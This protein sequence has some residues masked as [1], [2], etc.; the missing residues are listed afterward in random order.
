MNTHLSRRK[1]LASALH[2]AALAAASPRRAAAQD[3]RAKRPNIVFIL[4]DDLGW[5]DTAAY[6]SK[7]Y[8][9]PN[10]T[11]L[12]ERGMLFTEGYAACPLCSPTRASILTG[13]YPARLRFT[14]PSGHL[15]TNL[16]PP[17]VP[18]AVAKSRP[19]TTPTSP[20]QLGLE[21]VTIAEILKNAGYA[22][23]FVGKWHLG[24]EPYWPDKQ[25]F[26]VNVAGGHYPGPPSYF[27]P[28]SIETLAD[29]PEGEYLTD[30][31]TDEA[32]EFIEAQRSGPFFLALWHYTV[33]S[34]WQS[35]AEEEARFSEKADPRG[36]QRNPLIAGMIAS[37]DQSVGRILDALD[38]H[39][40]SEDTIVVFTSDNGQLTAVPGKPGRERKNTP[41]K[42]GDHVT[43]NAPLRGGKGL[44]YEG[45]VRVPYIVSWPGVVAPGSRTRAIASSIDF[46]PTFLAAAG[47]DAPEGHV[48]DGVSLLPVLTN[49]GALEREALFCH[50]P[51]YV[52]VGNKPSTSVRK[53][54][55]KLIRF[56]EGY[57]EL[58]DLESDIGERNNLAAVH[59]QKVAE[60]SELI[61]RFLVG[62]NAL[63]PKPN[64]N[65]D[66]AA[67]PEEEGGE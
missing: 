29:G 3:L 27:S 32:L 65:Y 20:T 34:P 67:P 40:L 33:H 2:A 49:A 58:Y 12:A 6:G 24:R 53:G 61:D 11:R 19:L 41:L 25:G 1:F 9:T 38:V 54:S 36:E 57:D 63:V 48:V 60:L 64:P 46:F 42:S 52:G 14:Q 17:S 30:R 26:D 62:T 28:Y 13:Q 8:E 23:G 4:A 37:F 59:P 51:H 16:E 31:L 35:K 39:G 66:P 43:S 56:Y 18:D 44:I 7:Y 22:T 47:L 50:F 45:G 21:T 55:W 10:I 15:P 5:M